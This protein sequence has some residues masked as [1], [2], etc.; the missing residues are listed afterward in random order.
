MVVVKQI[1]TVKKKVID[2]EKNW[3]LS[4]LILKVISTLNR[5]ESVTQFSEF[6]KLF[7]VYGNQMVDLAHLTGDRQNVN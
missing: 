3:I 5:L 6:V 4:Y 1:I 2:F 7:G